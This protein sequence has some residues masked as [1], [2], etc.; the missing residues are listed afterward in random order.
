MK[1]QFLCRKCEQNVFFVQLLVRP[2]AI[3]CGAG[4]CFSADVFFPARDLRDA[5]ANRREILLDGQY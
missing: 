2:E 4:L 1:C 5:W 3:A